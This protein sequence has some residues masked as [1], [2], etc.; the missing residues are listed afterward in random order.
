MNI[1]G[2]LFILISWGLIIGLNL[3]CFWRV[4]KEPTA[5]L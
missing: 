4:L 2:W 3:Y 5:E 1:F